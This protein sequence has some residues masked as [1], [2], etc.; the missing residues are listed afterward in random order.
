MI[1]VIQ[2]P[3]NEADMPVTGKWLFEGVKALGIALDLEGF[4]LSWTGGGTKM[5]VE[6][7]AENKIVGAALLTIGKKWTDSRESAMVLA[8][9]GNRAKLIEYCTNLATAFNMGYLAYEAQEHEPGV[10]SRVHRIDL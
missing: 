4:L 3:Q 2:P 8:M 10:L 1:K 5:I 7:D 6:V 9:E